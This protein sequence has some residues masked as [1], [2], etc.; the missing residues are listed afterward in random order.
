M[1]TYERKHGESSIE[2]DVAQRVLAQFGADW[3]EHFTREF[4]A[5]HLGQGTRKSEGVKSMHWRIWTILQG[6]QP[7]RPTPARQQPSASSS[8][9]Q[10]AGNAESST[11]SPVDDIHFFLSGDF[12]ELL[13]FSGS[14]CKNVTRDDV[15]EAFKSMALKWHPDKVH[16]QGASTA[17][18]TMVMQKLV[19]AR[20][21]LCNP[22]KRRCMIRS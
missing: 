5:E 15:L 12:C 20:E 22:E 2:E 17:R 21:V 9:A 13:G 3:E 4:L 8:S 14:N 19:E 7:P 6:L 1:G 10:S 11:S 16:Q 18:A